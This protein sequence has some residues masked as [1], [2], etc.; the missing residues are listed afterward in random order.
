MF[1]RVQSLCCASMCFYEGNNKWAGTK[2]FSIN[3]LHQSGQRKSRRKLWVGNEGSSIT[4]LSLSLRYFK[5]GAYWCCLRRFFCSFSDTACWPCSQ[6]CVSR[7][8]CGE[9][10]VWLVSFKQCT[11]KVRKSLNGSG[12]S[13]ISL[14]YI[15]K[16]CD[17]VA[18]LT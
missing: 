1:K 7:M 14:G 2:V 11:V 12:L 16:C 4:W 17:L 10:C 6:R 15:L 13:D 8:L 9:F 5:H 18:F 3:T